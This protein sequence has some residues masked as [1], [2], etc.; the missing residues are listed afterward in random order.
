M[1]AIRLRRLAV[2]AAAALTGLGATAPAAPATTS[3]SVTV[4]ND[5]VENVVAQIGVAGTVPDDDER[6]YLHKKKAGGS[7]CAA[8]PDADDGDYVM[9][10][11]LTT[12][13]DYAQS[14][15][16]TF[17]SAGT[18]LLCAWLKRTSDGTILLTDARTITVRVPRLGLAAA[19]SP[20]V[21]HAGEPFKIVASAQAEA[22]R[23]LYVFA[24]VDTGRG[25]PAN[26]SAADEGD[27]SN[28]FSKAVLGGPTILSATL[29]LN[30]PGAYLVC[31][32]FQYEYSFDPP[33]A[34]SAS[35][36]TVLAP[37]SPCVVPAVIAHEAV[38]QAKGRLAAASCTPGQVHYA[39][40]AHHARGTMLKFGQAAGT[41]LANA[42]TVDLYVSEGRP[43]IVPAI[44]SSR[45]VTQ[46]KRRLVASGCT[47]GRITHP[48]SRR[49]RRG[50]VVALTKP[51]GR[52][53]PP[54]TR[55]GIAVS[56]GRGWRQA[57]R[58]PIAVRRSLSVARRVVAVPPADAL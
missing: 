58:P 49:V 23:R 34:V 3:L 24:I 31:G 32:Y 22:E 13:G 15:N 12:A 30:T 33:E 36:F 50:R 35:A 25:C 4:G 1:N 47:V 17:W 14:S 45:S 44:P 48:R 55:I 5:P 53:L 26:A 7:G 46:V 28:P 40:S 2:L 19:A 52:R 29:M 57:A 9:Y 56:R 39:A 6:V 43:C 11:H 8:D 37:P 41:R 20:A 16:T 10:P 42:A 38:A 21:V 51:R 18:Y 27:V 54:R